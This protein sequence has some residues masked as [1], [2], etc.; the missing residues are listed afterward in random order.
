MIRLYGTDCDQVATVLKAIN[1]RASI[2]AG[3]FD[4][5]DI[6][7]EVDMLASAVNGGWNRISTVSVGNE[8]VNSGA[9]SVEQV[10]SAI[11]AARSALRAKGYTGPVI[12]VDTMMAIQSHPQLCEASD[13]CAI[14][15][16]AFFDGNVLPSDAGKFVSEWAQK[17]SK[18]AGGK[19]CVVAESGWPTQG[20][21]N[22]KAIPGQAQHRQAIQSLKASFS[23]DLILFTLY[24]DMWKSDRADTH[25]A[26]KYWGMRAMVK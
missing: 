25:S 1:G 9:A 5:K 13:Y 3:I 20:S 22:G 16:H 8:Q 11:G 4:I 21:V 2:F 15:C 7:K 10:T 19:R 6:Q 23:K 12:T 26:E 24:N 18:A 14:N 17:I